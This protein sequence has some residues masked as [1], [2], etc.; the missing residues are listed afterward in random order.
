ML[1]VMFKKM[2]KLVVCNHHEVIFILEKFIFLLAKQ[3]KIPPI[4]FF[5]PK[6]NH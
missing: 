6:T 3:S 4:L 2:A 1:L 5:R